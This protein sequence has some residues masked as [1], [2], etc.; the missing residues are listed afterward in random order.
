MMAWSH[1]LEEVIVNCIRNRDYEENYGKKDDIMYFQLTKEA[2]K[3]LEEVRKRYMSL[4][5]A[6]NCMGPED[7][8]EEEEE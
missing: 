2:Q 4:S 3:Y 1:I 7:F 6:V 5:E 8:V